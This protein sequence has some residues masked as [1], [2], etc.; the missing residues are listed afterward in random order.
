M[1]ARNVETSDQLQALPQQSK[2]GDI[3]TKQEN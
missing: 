2:T 1:P 3:M